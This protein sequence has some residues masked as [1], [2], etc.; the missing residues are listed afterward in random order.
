MR[1][2][3]SRLL[4][5]TGLPLVCV[6]CFSL[7]GGHWMALQMFAWAQMLRDYSRNA[8]IT[9]AIQ[10]TFSGTAPCTMCKVIA[11]KQQREEKTPSIVKLDKKTEG[12]SLS[13]SDLLRW[14][15]GK[16]FSYGPSRRMTLAKRFEA[17]P[18][19]IPIF[20]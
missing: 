12:T 9:E 16:D 17:P 4:K 6:A 11:E 8:P 7:A 15:E 19:P 14:P 1:H 13:M 20:C 10:K 3:F 2:P 18:V 5:I